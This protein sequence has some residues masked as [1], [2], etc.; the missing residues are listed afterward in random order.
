MHIQHRADSATPPGPQPEC[1]RRP[2]RFAARRIGDG[3]PIRPVTARTDPS[4]AAS[5]SHTDPTPSLLPKI[6]PQPPLSL[7]LSS[8]KYPIVNNL[9]FVV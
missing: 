6:T 4:T 8:L 9:L 5:Q 1:S 3:D 2:R 7:Y